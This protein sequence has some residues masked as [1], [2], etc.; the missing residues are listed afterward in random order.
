M[1][2]QVE[3]SLAEGVGGGSDRGMQGGRKLSSG[4]KREI[5]GGIE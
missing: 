5:G 1:G 4:G 3:P 2:G